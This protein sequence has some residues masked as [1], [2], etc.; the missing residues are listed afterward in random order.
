[1]KKHVCNMVDLFFEPLCFWKV[2]VVVK[3]HKHITYEETEVAAS[4]PS[5]RVCALWFQK[6][7]MSRC[8][9]PWFLRSVKNNGEMHLKLGTVPRGSQ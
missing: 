9:I 6:E 3:I 7:F 4:C 5:A 1:M 8:V 2:L